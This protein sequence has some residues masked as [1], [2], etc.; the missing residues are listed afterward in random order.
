MRHVVLVSALA[1]STFLSDA[2]GEIQLAQLL[3]AG[4]SNAVSV[5]G[6]YVFGGLGR[7]VLVIDAANPTQPTRIASEKLPAPYI[8]D[9]AIDGNLAFVATDDD[10][11]IL[12]IS[13]PLDPVM[14]GRETSTAAFGVAV[15][16]QIAY[17]TRLSQGIRSIDVSDPLHPV[18][19]GS[20]AVEGWP[21][22][23]RVIGSH[24]YVAGTNGGLAIVDVSNPSSPIQR[25]YVRYWGGGWDLDVVGTIAYVAGRDGVAIVDVSNPTAQVEIGRYDADFLDGMCVSVVGNYAYVLGAY[26]IFDV[27]DVSN[28]S[29]PVRVL[30]EITTGGGGIDIVNLDN[31]LYTADSE[32]SFRIREISDASA[33]T[34]EGMLRVL[35]APE[36]V[37][38]QNGSLYVGESWRLS[39][40]DVQDP[41]EPAFLG[42]LSNYYNPLTSLAPRGPTLFVGRS[43]SIL[44]GGD[45]GISVYDTSNL[46]A[47]SEVSWR[48]GF[49][50][51]WDIA[52]DAGYAYLLGSRSAGNFAFVTYD[53][54]NLAAPTEISSVSV[55]FLSS[56]F[57]IV[58]NLVLVAG[59]AGD[60]KI[61]DIT[62]H[63]QT[64]VLKSTFTATQDA[65]GVAA[66]GQVAFVADYAIGLIAI[67]ISAP[68]NP[69]EIGRLSGIG[70]PREL[71]A[72]YPHV[73]LAG[74]D[75]LL[76]VVD[77]S[78]PTSPSVV[79]SYNTGGSYELAV[80]GSTI[81]TIPGYRGSVLL[82]DAPILNV[83]TPVE[84]HYAR[85]VTLGAF[86]N[87]FN[88]QVTI[89]FTVAS[90]REVT[91]QIFDATGRAVWSRA[92][93][94]ATAGTHQVT[95]DGRDASGNPCAS[96]VYF[97]RLDAGNE[98]LS[99]KLVLLK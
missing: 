38:L 58:G 5:Q 42:S 18:V 45:G 48:W 33:P 75:P 63:H 50:S 84:Q 56:N 21:V 67:D 43:A 47:P 23:I 26:D 34:T 29:S 20:G 8:Y 1:I 24:A 74:N 80:E 65:R 2:S 4:R 7:H 78:D 96:G 91:L 54:S 85:T 41:Y 95:W 61:Y 88:P 79:D 28:P 89:T 76:R 27:V 14:L 39:T 57:D 49:D 93:R 59:G 11:S 64:P 3:E 90:P 92:Q 12:D 32:S 52:A 55:P 15:S 9:I 99:R 77:V 83:A 10:L 22:G 73:V 62:N 97:C 60:L 37:A 31:R 25:S 51:V 16:G 69:V 66:L 46:S 35:S 36:S 40:M 44:D 72:K 71:V 94:R 13:N 68:N 19:I 82:L 70:Q 6:D 53:I 86:P 17:A 30:R 98:V 87:P 81:A